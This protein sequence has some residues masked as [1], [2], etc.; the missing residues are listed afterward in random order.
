MRLLE[1]DDQEALERYLTNL[2]RVQHQ[3]KTPYDYVEFQSNV[4]REFAARLDTDESVKFYVKLPSSFHVDTP[5]GPYNPDWAIMLNGVGGT[6]DR[7]C[8]VRETKGSLDSDDL[9]AKEKAKIDCGRKHFAA[10]GVNYAVTPSFE[11]FKRSLA[12]SG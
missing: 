12:A 7:L 6:L 5:I 4:E 1:P 10:I 2:Y 8:F 9:R 3:D 11:E